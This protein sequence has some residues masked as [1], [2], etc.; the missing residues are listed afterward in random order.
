MTGMHLRYIIFIRVPHPITERSVLMDNES[1]KF[2]M[3]KP[4]GEEVEC[5][6][7]FTFEHRET[8]R[9]YVVYTDYSFDPAGKTKV[10]AAWYIPNSPDSKLMPIESEEEWHMIE[11]MLAELQNEV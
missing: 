6:I 11:I 9:N 7:L 2:M 1:M 10:F 8:G 4:N 5:E 3:V